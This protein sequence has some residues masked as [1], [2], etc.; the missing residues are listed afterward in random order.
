MK[1]CDCEQRSKMP[2]NYYFS[3]DIR[4]KS[5]INFNENI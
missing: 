5:Q 2:K 3:F 4:K 1:I